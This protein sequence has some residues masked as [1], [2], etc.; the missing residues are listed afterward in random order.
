[1]CYRQLKQ[2][3]K[4][5]IKARPT[6]I[7]WLMSR[8]KHL[9]LRS[10][11]PGTKQ[12]PSC[13]SAP[14]HVLHFWIKYMYHVIPC[15]R[16][17]LQLDFLSGVEI[18]M[19]GDTNF[20]LIRR[21]EGWIQSTDTCAGYQYQPWNYCHSIIWYDKIRITI[22]LTL[23]RASLTCSRL[24]LSKLSPFCWK[25]AFDTWFVHVLIDYYS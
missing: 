18:L 15:S 4:A 22:S 6:Q 10:H 17:L 13:L 2:H 9:S 5:R 11:T 3:N 19:S 25:T 20:R 1:M 24:D 16:S 21:F 8:L 14:I 7:R 12:G 23:T